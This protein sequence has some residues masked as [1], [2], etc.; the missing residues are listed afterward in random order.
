MSFDYAFICYIINIMNVGNITKCYLVKKQMNLN[1]NIR[2]GC[3]RF[4]GRSYHFA[5]IMGK[6]LLNVVLN[7]LKLYEIISQ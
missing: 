1:L 5:K 7:H 3:D 6:L 4:K 2:F